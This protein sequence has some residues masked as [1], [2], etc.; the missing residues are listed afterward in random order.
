MIL[1]HA[2][3]THGIAHLN[4]HALQRLGAV[5][6][7]HPQSRAKEHLEM[8]GDTDTDTD[9]KNNTLASPLAFGNQTG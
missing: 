5:K 9:R 1:V 8:G 6:P 7:L 3:I 2:R 4:S